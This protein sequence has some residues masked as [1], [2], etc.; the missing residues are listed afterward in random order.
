MTTKL[1]TC[2]M[3]AAAAIAMSATVGLAQDSDD[4]SADQVLATVNGVDITLGHVI[5]TRSNLPAEYGQLPA[6]LLF[7]GILDQLVQ[8]TLLGQTYEGELSLQSKIFLENEE[9]AIIAGEAISAFLAEDVDEEALRAAYDEQYPE[10]GDELEYRASHI[11]VETEDE[12]NDL[13]TELEGGAVFSALAQERSTG[14]SAAVGG[15]LGWFG[16]GDM[17]APFFDAV[18]ELEPGGVSAPVQTQ[19]GWHVI[20]LAET[21]AV[22]RPAFEDVR[23][24]I[25]DGLQQSKLEGHIDALSAEAEIDRPDTS[26]IDPEVITRIDLLEN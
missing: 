20:T 1:K 19:F 12:A 11:L 18:V 25:A 9:R 5:A 10:V 15:D 6:A 26:G 4:L 16:D 8:Q 21:R 22:Q 24:A 13:I 23:D 17:V 3:G 14:P 2:L 7:Q